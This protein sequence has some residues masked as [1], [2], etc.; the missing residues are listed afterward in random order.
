MPLED[1][2]VVFLYLCIVADYVSLVTVDI[3]GASRREEPQE[4]RGDGEEHEFTW[5]NASSTD[6]Y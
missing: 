4:E 6:S 1:N 5:W 2:N 3:H